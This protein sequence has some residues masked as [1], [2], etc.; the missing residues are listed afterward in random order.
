MRLLHNKPLTA[1]RQLNRHIS[2]GVEEAILKALE[3]TTTNRF[4]SIEELEKHLLPTTPLEVTPPAVARPFNMSFDG[5][6]AKNEPSGW[7]N[8]L[9]LVGNVSTAY[10]I[11]VLPRP[12]DGKGRCVLFHHPKANRVEFGSL[13]QRCPA[14]YLAG[15]IIRFEGEVRTKDVEQWAGLWLRADGDKIPSLF[16][17]NMHNRP[18]RGSTSWTKYMIDAQLPQDTRWLNYGILLV[19]RGMMWADNFRLMVWSQEGRW[20]DV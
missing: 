1:P 20:I 5:P 17:D 15:Q 2:L 8:S 16:F 3:L 12:D 6:T 4:Q 19:G 10:K 9:G 11:R 7:F 13:M 18:I 14:H